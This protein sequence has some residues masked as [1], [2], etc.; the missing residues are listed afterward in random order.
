MNPEIKEIHKAHIKPLL[1]KPLSNQR[2]K[3][4]LAIEIVPIG[5]K[6]LKQL[7]L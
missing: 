4:S 3:I 7:S 5:P 1:G 6:C 2:N